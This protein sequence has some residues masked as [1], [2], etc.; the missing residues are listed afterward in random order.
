MVDFSIEKVMRVELIIRGPYPVRDDLLV[1]QIVEGQLSGLGVYENKLS[2]VVKTPSGDALQIGE[3]GVFRG[4]VRLLAQMDDD[5][6]L[7]MQYGGRTIPNDAYVAKTESGAEVSGEDVYFM[8]Q[9]TFDTASP[10]Y[11]WLSEHIFVGKMVSVLMPVPNA[12]GRVVYEIAK[13]S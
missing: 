9:P 5:S 13:V 12:D 8:I 3:N 7:H 11:S 6:F 1:I 4:N 2:G 10:K